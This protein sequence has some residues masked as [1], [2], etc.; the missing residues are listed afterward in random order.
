MTRTTPPR[1][2]DIAAEFP[3]IAPYA[4]TATRLHPRPGAPDIH[5]SSIGGPL[6]WPVDE[7]WP[8]CH[9]PH[10]E[11]WPFKRL[12]TVRQER[13][14]QSLIAGRTRA[15]EG[16]VFTAEEQADL[17]RLIFEEVAAEGPATM[18]AV[19]Q[20]Y[21]RDVPDL[22]SPPGTDLLQVLWCPREHPPEYCPAVTLRWRRSADVK[23]V[24]D[25][26]PEPVVVE[27]DDYVPEPCVLHPE[28]IVEYPY[29]GDLPGDLE[30]QIKPWDEENGYLY[31]EALSIC[32]GWKIGGHANGNLTDPGPMICEC[33]AT[34]ELLMAI[35][36]F[37]WADVEFGWRPLE[38]AKPPEFQTY[39]S[40][41]RPTGINISR[42][43]GLW[44]FTCPVSF[45]HPHGLRVQ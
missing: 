40:P 13:R 36:S 22:E 25:P 38:D 4:R 28:Q 15:G 31:Q 26:Q 45:A 14:I 5:T 43:Y 32:T 11:E 18:L 34:M 23:E 42:G 29:L 37:E 17:T 44:V 20:L 19:A 10:S 7:P 16:K 1:P 21:V 12:A 30:Q 3:R 24:L 39:P 2:V 33:G 6:L 9:E 41:S 8:V 35:D 27:N